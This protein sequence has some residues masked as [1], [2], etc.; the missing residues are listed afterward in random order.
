MS[1]KKEEKK[2]KNKRIEEKRKWKKKLQ[3]RGRIREKSLPVLER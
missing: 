2:A 1:K 3:K